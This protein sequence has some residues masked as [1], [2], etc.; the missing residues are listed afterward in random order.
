M[1]DFVAGMRAILAAEKD[2]GKAFEAAR[3][4]LAR[5]LAE[6]ALA[7]A[8]AKWPVCNRENW[9]LFEDP[10]Y[11]FVLDGLIKAPGQKT[12]IHDHGPIWVLYGLLS[13]GEDICH[14]ERTDG[15]RGEGPARIAETGRST[16]A[17]GMLDLVAPYAIHSEEAGAKGSVAVILRSARPDQVATGRFDPDAAYWRES[18]GIRQVS[19]PLL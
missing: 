13:G 9:L 18:P 4:H 12:S 6:P 10:D 3:P 15:G 1:M 11:G 19:M 17:P 8:A 16:V 7:R 5:L 14:F 2:F